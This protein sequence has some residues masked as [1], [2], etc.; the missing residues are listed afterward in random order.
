MENSRKSNSADL[1]HRL[2]GQLATL[3]PPHSSV[4]VAFSGGVDS[5][6]LLHLLHQFAPRFSWQLS[7]LHV[8]HG[9]SPHA[10]EWADFCEQRC[11]AY[12][13]SF[14]LE[15]V[16]IQPLREQGIEAAARQLRY[17]AYAKYA[18]DFL[19]LAHHA[20]D[21][22]ETVLLQLL[23][24]SGVRGASAMPMLA[25]R[26][27][28]WLRPLLH[29]TRAEIVAYAQTH[30]LSW[31]EDESNAD[32]SYP[33]N[34]LRHQILPILNEKFPSYR[35]TLTR[36]AQHFAEASEL[37]DEL[38]QLDA[39]SAMHDDT[40]QIAALKNLSVTRA[41]NLLR[42]F[43]QTRGASM[44]QTVQLDDML[45]QLIHAR[46]DA[47]V[48]VEFSG[49]QVRRYQ[50]AV[51]V[52]PALPDFDAALKLV[53]ENEVSLPWVALDARIDFELS[54]GRGISLAK[55]RSAPVTLRFRQG[56][57]VLKP[58][59]SATTRTL[60]NLM[61]EQHIPPWLRDRA[62]LLF[63]GEELVCAPGVIAA[64]FQSGVGE[65]GVEMRVVKNESGEA[66]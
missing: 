28:L 58:R 36:S 1:A 35:Q 46:D 15:R 38:A 43:L 51:Y 40:L 42:Y 17:A 55:L 31:I 27:T 9:I 30:H 13:L 5:V 33:R 45:Q 24:G 3:I 47:N 56:G 48:C 14:Y 2:A 11:A 52:L 32:D 23:R 19:V 12:K 54:Q 4:L 53:W 59:A 6:V 7:V 22:A 63:C 21:Q 60:K 18:R 61:Q 65:A 29:Y 57:E 41:K 62:P 49:W 64:N 10:D 39:V 44:P 34:F 66:G 20:D 50:G 25:R 16:D 8:H 37:L 26:A